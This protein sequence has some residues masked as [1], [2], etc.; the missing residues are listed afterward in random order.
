MYII[1]KTSEREN[2]Y[3]LSALYAEVVGQSF[4]SFIVE[5]FAISWCAYICTYL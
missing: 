3:F 2:S 1:G 4:I 5:V